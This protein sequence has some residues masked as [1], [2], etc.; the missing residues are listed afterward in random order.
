MTG[1]VVWFTG[2]PRSGKSSLARAVRARLVGHRPVAILDGDEVR[3]AL[4]PTPGYDPEG[5]D[6]F[7]AT[8]ARLAALLASQGLVVLVPATAHRRSY[9][10]RARALAP[11]FIE[12]HLTGSLA[13]CIKRDPAGLYATTAHAALPGLGV[14]YE[15]P[16]TADLRAAGGED[17]EAAAAVA[18]AVLR[19]T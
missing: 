11:R 19:M 17:D 8:L 15:P 5:R 18:A 16:H 3:A 14:E 10:E 9:R 13:E 6:A 12:V 4:V 1:V 2:L 7:Y